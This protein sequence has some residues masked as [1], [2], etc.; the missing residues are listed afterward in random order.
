M[1]LSTDTHMAIEYRCVLPIRGENQWPD[2]PV[3]FRTQ[4]EQWIE[5]MRVLGMIVMKAY[6]VSLS[7]LFPAYDVRLYLQHG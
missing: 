2:R 6:V 3:D 7:A 1:W 4:M 5:K